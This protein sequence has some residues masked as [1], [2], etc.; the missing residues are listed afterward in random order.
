MRFQRDLLSLCAPPPHT[1]LLTHAHFDVGYHAKRQRPP[2]QS[3]HTHT[4]ARSACG[5]LWADEHSTGPTRGAG[6]CAHSLT[7]CRS[8]SLLPRAPVFLALS[9]LPASNPAQSSSSTREGGNPGDA[10]SIWLYCDGGGATNL[11]RVLASP[12]P[13]S[14]KSTYTSSSSSSSSVTSSSVAS[15]AVTAEVR[16]GGVRST[17]SA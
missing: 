1:K 15:P 11:D 3:T 10:G 14:S 16:A 7:R 17:S 9:L 6:T 12:P 8:G 13:S 4:Y 5:Q 2:P